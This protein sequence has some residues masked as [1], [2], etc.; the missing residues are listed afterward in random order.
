[1]K[2]VILGASGMIGHQLWRRLNA[3]YPDCVWGTVRKAKEH[4]EQFKFFNMKRLIGNIE[5]SDFEK[6]KEVLNTVKP[7]I[8]LNCIGLTL[9]KK[10]M[11]NVF[12]C[13]EVNGML[14]HRID[15]WAKEN[16]SKLIHFSTDC[17]FDGKIGSYSEFSAPS[18][19]DL[20]GQTKYLGEVKHSE[21]C[22]T[23]RVPV[24]GRE[25]EGKTELIEWFLSQKN[26][27]AKGFASVYYSG[28]TTIRLAY[29]IITI[30][31]K[32]PKLSGIIQIST[33][34]ISKYNL[35]LLL[36]KY[37]DTN[38]EL[39]V[40]NTI[41]SD[42]SLNADKYK[43]LTDFKAPSWEAMIKELAEDRDGYI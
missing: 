36:D 32:Y 13:L 4:Y 25:I 27:K 12:L 34:K 33:N 7:D 6:V 37:F 43:Q 9:R 41:K 35:L 18:A 17:V 20:Y 2:I 23:I 14:P 10:E 31:E 39:E 5:A 1:M 26:S 40:D 28:I 16:N 11:E 8:V 19:R 30:I 15:S 24:I 38:V 22:L 42:K 3:K 29:E 21:S